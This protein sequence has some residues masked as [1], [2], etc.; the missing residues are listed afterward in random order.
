MWI[1]LLVGLVAIGMI[2]RKNLAKMNHEEQLKFDQYGVDAQELISERKSIIELSTAKNPNR[3]YK[4]ADKKTINSV[5]MFAR[6]EAVN[7]FI[8]DAYRA[9]L[10]NGYEKDGVDVAG[11]HDAPIPVVNLVPVSHNPKD[12]NAVEIHVGI[13]ENLM[14]HIGHVPREQCLEVRKFLGDVAENQILVLNPIL[15][16]LRGAGKYEYEHGVR[17]YILLFDQLDD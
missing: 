9:G 6:P 8:H 14:Y 4:V 7:S 15:T 16:F 2:I 1:V 10:L 12:K 13:N 17:V 5:G 11:F 3:K